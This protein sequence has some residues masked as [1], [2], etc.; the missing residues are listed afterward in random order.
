MRIDAITSA[1]LPEL[2]PLMRAYCDFYRVAPSDQK[3]LA[4]SQ[5]LIDNPAE[6][7]QM[8]ARD[9]GGRA[10]GF[11]TLFWTWQTLDADRVGVLNDLYTVPSARGTGVGHALIANCRQRCRDRGVPKLVWE[12]APDNATAQRLY[13]A[14]GAEA[15]TW[16]AYEIEAASST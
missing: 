16:V 10:V 13:D 11:A 12:T 7:E 9:E 5:A 3:L 2:M 4:L 15:S 14:M 8:I 1:D 6:G